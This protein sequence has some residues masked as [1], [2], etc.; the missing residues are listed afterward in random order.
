MQS[1]RD[2]L[3]KAL[4]EDVAPAFRLEVPLEQQRVALDAIG[5]NAMLPEGA[6]FEPRALAGLPAQWVVGR[7]GRTDRALLHLHGGG[8]VMGTCQSHRGLSAWIAEATGVQVVIPEYR[9]APEHPFPAALEDAIACYHALCERLDP[10]AIALVGDSAGGGLTLAT[11]LSLRDVGARLPAA[12][13]VLS[14]W[15]DM[16]F[17]GATIKTRAAIDPWIDPSLLA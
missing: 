7:G 1:I 11:L 6:T 4:I 16:T 14:P 10:S 15:T 5:A 13:V 9:L 2:T 8:Y 17:S 3:R 12:A